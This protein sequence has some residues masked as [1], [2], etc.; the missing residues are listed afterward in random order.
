[1]GR[2]GSTGNADPAHCK[3]AAISFFKL[4]IDSFALARF[5]VS[6]ATTELVKLSPPKIGSWPHSLRVVQRV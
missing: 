1:M 4:P 6:N 2:S 5:P 3:L